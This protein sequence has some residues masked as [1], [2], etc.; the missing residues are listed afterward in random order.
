M[1]NIIYDLHCDTISK[2]LEGENYNIYEND[3]GFDI[4]KARSTGIGLQFFSLFASDKENVLKEILLQFSKFHQELERHKSHLYHLLSYD[5]I[6]EKGNKG[7]IACLLHLEGA[8][9]IG[10]SID[11]LKLFYYMGLRSI[12]L[13]WNYSNLLAD[14]VLDNKNNGL[15]PFGKKIIYYLNS[16]RIIFDLAHISPKSFYQALEIYEKPILVSHANAKSICCH[17]RNLD[18]KQLKVLAQ[19]E[20]LIGITLYKDFIKEENASL[21][22]FIDHIRYIIDLIGIKYLALGSDFDGANNM[23]LKDVSYYPELIELLL[24]KGFN[25]KEVELISYKNA[26]NFLK[27]VLS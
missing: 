17:P 22:D 7:K 5:Q 6:K 23:I 18:K 20:G 26:D 2:L 14:G 1:I 8:E 24:R 16:Q 27:L 13:T 3:L 9:A 12:A 10:N 4:K 21:D 11:L 15:T 25:K 19:H